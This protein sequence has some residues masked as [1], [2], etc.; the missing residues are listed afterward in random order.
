MSAKGEPWSTPIESALE[1][2][3]TVESKGWL[4]DENLDLRRRPECDVVTSTNLKDEERS[5]YLASF[6]VPGESF[7]DPDLFVVCE[8]S[9]LSW[10]KI[11]IMHNGR[12]TFRSATTDSEYGML[13]HLD[14]GL[15]WNLDNSM[16]D[17]NV[18]Q[19]RVFLEYLKA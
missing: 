14:N 18:Q 13:K 19:A 6:I 5:D 17:C 16:Q 7:E 4:V 2:L 12:V 15:D 11:M 1:A 8:D 9:N 10:R 3:E